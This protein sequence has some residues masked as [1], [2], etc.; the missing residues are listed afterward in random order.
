MTTKS[1]TNEFH[2]SGQFRLRNEALNANRFEYNA[3]QPYTSRPP[4]KQQGYSAT[5][6]GPIWLPGM[7]NGKDR[8]FYFL[9]YEGFRFNQ[10][11]DCFRTVPTERER[12]GIFPKAWRRSARSSSLSPCSIRSL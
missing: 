1:G 9:S 11:L 5:L 2:G 10:A 4:F 3:G 12:R 6:G 7:Y 8:S